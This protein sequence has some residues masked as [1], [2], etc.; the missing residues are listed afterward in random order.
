MR[1]R[2]CPGRSSAAT[3]AL[4]C[5]AQRRARVLLHLVGRAERPVARPHLLLRLVR[6]RRVDDA[7]QRVVLPHAEAERDGDRRERDDEPRAQLMQVLD[8]R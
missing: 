6:E 1:S 4:S 2:R 5:C 7:K 3:T 8:D